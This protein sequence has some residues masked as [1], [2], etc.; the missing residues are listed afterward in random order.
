MKEA[1]SIFR[2][3]FSCDLSSANYASQCV[4]RLPHFRRESV[5]P[6]SSRLIH[7]GCFSP[8]Q[9]DHNPTNSPPPRLILPCLPAERGGIKPGGGFPV[10]PAPLENPKTAR[11][12]RKQRHYSPDDVPSS[13]TDILQIL[14]VPSQKIVAARFVLRCGDTVSTNARDFTSQQSGLEIVG[15][16]INPF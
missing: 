13:I 11:K 7:A 12:T 5:C 9:E 8:R 10:R 3:D 2:E 16:R 15:D 4:P 14:F 1:I 6:G